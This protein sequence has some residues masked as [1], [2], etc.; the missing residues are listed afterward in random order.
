MSPPRFRDSAVCGG[1]C[2]LTDMN[3]E[4]SEDSMQRRDFAKVV[5]LGVLGVN[6]IGA[7]A[8]RAAGR[9]RVT[10]SERKQ[11]AREHLRGLGSLVMPSFSPDFTSLDEEGVRYDVRHRI[12]QGFCSTMVS[13]TGA[14]AE[15]RRRIMEIVREEARGKMLMSV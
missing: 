15:Q 1:D 9:T 3:V 13:A 12:K 4:V 7:A 11:W 5:G 14:T 6:S 2:S 10:E 8:P